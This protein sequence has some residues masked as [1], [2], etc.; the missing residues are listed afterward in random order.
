M[1]QTQT[2]SVTSTEIAGIGVTLDRTPLDWLDHYDEKIG[3]K[4][5]LAYVVDDPEPQNPLETMD[6]EG[7]IY[8]ASHGR[9]AQAEIREALAINE[10]GDPDFELLQ[11][12]PEEFKDRWVQRAVKDTEFQEWCFKQPMLEQ[13]PGETDEA[14]YRS[15]ANT[16]WDEWGGCTSPNS[17]VFDWDFTAA[18]ERALFEELR[19]T[20]KIG[21]PDAVLLDIYEHSG[22]RYSVSGTGMQDPWDTT[23]GGAV[24]IPDD[25]AR[26]EI[27]RRAE[28]YQFGSIEGVVR[29]GKKQWTMVFD[30]DESEDIRFESWHE[31]FETAQAWVAERTDG[32]KALGRRRAAADIA[33]GACE[34]YTDFCN[35]SVFGVVVEV[36]EFENGDDEATCVEMDEVYGHYGFTH[37]EEVVKESFEAMVAKLKSEAE[38]SIVH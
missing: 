24:W 31:C 16:Y 32:N 7:R 27:S 33:E 3:N 30:E 15:V 22:V 4:I 36:H 12:F 1:F 11:D 21:D 26:E 28:V 29:D 8:V 18:V 5:V 2:R 23:R 20:G 35:G 37:A 19:D 25:C 14:F 34:L 10:F 13:E 17:E 6:G 9:E 38:Q